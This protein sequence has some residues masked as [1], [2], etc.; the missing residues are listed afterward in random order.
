M[1]IHSTLVGREPTYWKQTMSGGALDLESPDLTQLP[2]RDLIVPLTRIPRF[3][4]HTKV[5]YS[6]ADHSLHC[7]SIALAGL[8]HRVIPKALSKADTTLLACVLTHDLHEALIGDMPAPWKPLLGRAWEKAEK[9]MATAVADR[10]GLPYP[11]PKRIADAVRHADL[12]A[13][14]TEY[15]DLLEKPEIAWNGRLPD[16]DQRR[17]YPRPPLY[18]AFE[19]VTILGSLGFIDVAEASIENVS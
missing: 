9:S 2:I 1:A 6:V 14:A 17:V 13:L 3:L 8:G 5:F 11:Y 15:R 10:L 16:P 7:F 4:G 18:L 12:V 19:F